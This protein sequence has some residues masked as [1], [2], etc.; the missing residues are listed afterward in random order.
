MA[1]GAEREQ[2]GEDHGVG[3]PPGLHVGIDID[4]VP[5]AGSCQNGQVEGGVVEQEWVGR[6]GGEEGGHVLGQNEP[7]LPPVEC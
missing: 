1:N 6:M 3:Y 5:L 4:A 7:A 2:P